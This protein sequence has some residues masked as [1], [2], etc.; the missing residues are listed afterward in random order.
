ME[1]MEIR[2]QLIDACLWLQAKGL[3]IGT[4]GNVSVRLD[5]QRILLTPSAVPYDTMTPEDLVIVDM[6]G[7]KTEGSRCPTSEM[8]LHRLV[9]LA[10]PDIHAVVHC[11][12]VYASAM[13]ALGEGIP[14]ILEDMPQL[15]G[16]GVPVTARYISA[17]NHLELAREAAACMGDKNAVLLRN[18]GAVG[19]GRSLSEA[20]VCCQVVEKAS[21]CYLAV[22]DRAAMQAIPDE[23][24]AKER[25]RF[26]YHYGKEE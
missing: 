12:S 7:K 1:L 23:E 25:Y 13:C 17:G 24:A 16:G 18:H 10:R 19:C 22:G 26:L 3:V 11:H 14:A 4:W 2:Q 6:E 21:Q 9:Y 5:E 20:L 8:Q 15:I